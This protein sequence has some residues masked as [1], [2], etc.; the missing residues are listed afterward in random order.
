MKEHFLFFIYLSNTFY[1]S[2]LT[3]LQRGDS[4]RVDLKLSGNKLPQDA[5]IVIFFA[6][7]IYED[8]GKK[9]MRL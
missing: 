6:R 7:E 9:M 8:D 1:L 5:E 4:C 3:F 2:F